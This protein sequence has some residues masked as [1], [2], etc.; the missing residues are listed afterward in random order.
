MLQEHFHQLFLSDRKMLHLGH[1]AEVAA[2]SSA[3]NLWDWQSTRD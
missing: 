1:D 2:D 3:R